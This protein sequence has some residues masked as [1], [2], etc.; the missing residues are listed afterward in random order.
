[1]SMNENQCWL[2]PT[3]HPALAGDE[4]HVWRASL[5]P[6]EG[7]ILRLEQTLDSDERNRADRFYFPKDRVAFV[8]S[9][10]VLRSLLGRYLGAPPAEIQ[11]AYNARG[12]PAC[13][14]DAGPSPLCFNL[15]H[16]GQLALYAV[17][18]GREVGVDVERN[19]PLSDFRQ[20]AHR[21]FSEQETQTLRSLPTDQ[22][23]QAF[24]NCWTR[25]EA[26]IKGRGEGLS[27]PL[28]A[29]DVT[30]APGEPAALL[31][32]R[33]DPSAAKSWRL[34]ELA[35]GPGYTAALAAEGQDWRASCWQWTL[36]ED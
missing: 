10:G 11:F 18:R 9:R 13:R 5:T 3:S 2:A 6:P 25:K 32:D 29:F 24:F 33:S 1:M 35:P 28:H 17:A 16:S 7:Q 30:L 31:A 8:V 12:K 26:Y 27:H 19:R 21:Y 36:P 34:Q 22:Q 20:I 14:C 4:V 23:E 15:S